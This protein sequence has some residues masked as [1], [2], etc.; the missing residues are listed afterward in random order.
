MALPSEPSPVPA[1][2][3][4]VLVYNPESTGD[5]PQRA[6]RARSELAD[7]APHLEV[8]AVPTEY[9]GHARVIAEQEARAGRA[10]R[11]VGQR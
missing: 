9:A 7:A 5:G 8:V 11:G 1:Y 6:V 3:R 4:V 2:E 10:A